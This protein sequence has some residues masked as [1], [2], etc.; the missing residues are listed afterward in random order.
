MNSGEGAVEGR[1]HQAQALLVSSRGLLP[2]QV[3]RVEVE[4]LAMKTIIAILA[5]VVVFILLFPLFGVSTCNGACH[6]Q[7]RSGLSA[8]T[9]PGPWLEQV[10]MLMAAL[11]GL[12]VAVIPWKAWPK[13]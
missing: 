4:S 12:T 3:G 8:I 5:G 10:P 6:I 1:S 7:E 11:A 13:R 2:F 9:Y